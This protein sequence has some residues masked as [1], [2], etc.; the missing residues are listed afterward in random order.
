MM[1]ASIYARDQTCDCLVL[2]G[3]GSSVFLGRCQIHSDQGLHGWI[4]LR[5]IAG[6]QSGPPL[7]I[8]GGGIS[9]CDGVVEGAQ[10]PGFGPKVGP[11]R[12]FRSCLCRISVVVRSSIHTDR[13]RLDSPRRRH[14]RISCFLSRRDQRPA[15]SNLPYPDS[16]RRNKRNREQAG[17]SACRARRSGR[18]RSLVA[19]GRNARTLA[20]I[21]LPI[22]MRASSL[23]CCW[24]LLC[25]RVVMYW[26]H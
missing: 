7:H 8:S 10:E 19:M 17:R 5:T 18:R 24:S 25:T 12:Q 4:R 3:H 26:P 9:L 14:N 16:V 22:S 1:G 2:C 11:S 13:E 21:F 6:R 15:D 23:W 20:E